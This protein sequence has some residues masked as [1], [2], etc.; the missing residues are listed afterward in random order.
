M[1]QRWVAIRKSLNQDWSCSVVGSEVQQVRRLRRAPSPRDSACSLFRLVS[2]SILLLFVGLVL[3]CSAQ[4]EFEQR[5]Q[6]G[7]EQ[8][9]PELKF[10]LRTKVERSAYHLFETIPIEL[11]YSSS[12][13]STYSIEIDETMN[14]AGWTHR[15]Y[16][17]PENTVLL[18]LLEFET[19]GVI[20]CESDRQYLSRQPTVLKRELTDYI[21]FEKAGTYRLFHTTQRVFKGALKKEDFGPSTIILTSNILTL[22][23][24][25]DDPDWDV[26]QLTEALRKL[27]DPRVQANYDAMKQRIEKIGS[28]LGQDVAMA[29]LLDQTELVQTEKRLNALDTEEAIHERVNLM[30]MMSK[31]DVQEERDYG[32]GTELWQPLLRST[33]RPDVVVASM[34]ARAEDPGFGV[35]YDYL[36]WWATYT[37]LR[38]HTEL[39]RPFSD[40]A[41]HQKRIHSFLLCKIAEEKDIVLRLESMLATKKGVAKD[42]TALAIE[43]AKGFIAY[44]TQ[45]KNQTPP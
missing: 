21:R 19:H 43:T 31:E 14:F 37:V 10:V 1:M 35:D 9:P 18:T 11:A 20:C 30:D 7:L 22:T 34:K 12:R 15:F 39:F 3:D 38:D 8:N 23:I 32:G 2:A 45:G 26:Q 25:P 40:E 27:H 6:K 42:V 17:E 5:N 29:N 33:T 41:E 4:T 44:Q 36:D 28:E 16:V 13:P 24:L